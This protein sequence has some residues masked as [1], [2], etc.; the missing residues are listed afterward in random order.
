MKLYNV[1]DYGVNATPE[2]NNANLINQL[3]SDIA[4]YSTIYFPTGEY[5]ILESILVNKRISFIGD[6]FNSRLVRDKI[7]DQGSIF[8]FN[9]P[10]EDSSQIG[11]AHV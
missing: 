1:L 5:L 4:E 8:S 7:F 11:R 10:Y 2:T 9:L 6:G 3:I